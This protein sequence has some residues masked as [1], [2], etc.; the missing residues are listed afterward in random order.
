MATLIAELASAGENWSAPIRAVDSRIRRPGRDRS[1]RWGCLCRCRVN[2]SP[3]VGRWRDRDP[4]QGCP[5]REP[6]AQVVVRG[7]RWWFEEVRL[8]LK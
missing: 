7:G 5:L 2:L 1:R 4:G 6:A 8:V 3:D